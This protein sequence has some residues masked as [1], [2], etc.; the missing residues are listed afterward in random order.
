MSF[1][2][3][4]ASPKEFFKRWRPAWWVDEVKTGYRRANKWW[5]RAAYQFKHGYLSPETGFWDC[6]GNQ[7]PWIFHNAG[8]D[9]ARVWGAYDRSDP[10]VM[11]FVRMAE[12]GKDGNPYDVT[13]HNNPEWMHPELVKQRDPMELE[14]WYQIGMPPVI[15]LGLP[16]HMPKPSWTQQQKVLMRRWAR[17]GIPP[18]PGQEITRHDIIFKDAQDMRFK[19][20]DTWIRES[21]QEM[22]R[23]HTSIEEREKLYQKYKDYKWGELNNYLDIHRERTRTGTWGNWPKPSECFLETDRAEW[24]EMYP[25]VGAKSH[26]KQNY[27]SADVLDQYEEAIKRG[28][29]KKKGFSWDE[30]PYYPHEAPGGVGGPQ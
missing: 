29:P 1:A 4:R 27:I 30:P 16:G 23:M 15:H 13:A 19:F 22:K 28:G 5:A 25:K 10:D 20:P 12:R 21:I 9:S 18:K 14:E 3:S 24:G 6:M 26:W 8:H 7:N 2:G 17:Q 11:D